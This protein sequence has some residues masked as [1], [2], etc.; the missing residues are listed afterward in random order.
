MT[1]IS[2]EL[3]PRDDLVRNVEFVRAHCPEVDTINIPDLSSLTIR[4]TAVVGRIPSTFH[5]IPHL[6]TASVATAECVTARIREAS[7]R[8]ILVISGDRPNLFSTRSYPT[9][10]FDVLKELRGE[11]PELRVYAALDPYRQSLRAELQYA[12]QK[13]HAGFD[14]F[15]TQPFFDLNLMQAYR[16]HLAS[17]PVFW[18]LTPVLS[19]GSQSYWERRNNVVFPKRF[20]PTTDWNI[21]YGRKFVAHVRAC[22]MDCYIMPL[23]VSLAEYLPQVL[24]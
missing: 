20:R 1:R 4:S 6:P 19:E 13:L 5:V 3:V 22:D 15:F 7:I 12:E 9:S 10:I 14:G 24:G 16:Q 11:L 8:E 18:G 23:R 21:G 17:V 2:V